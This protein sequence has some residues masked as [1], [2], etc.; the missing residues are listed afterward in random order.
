SNHAT[1][2]RHRPTRFTYTTLFR[3]IGGH[4]TLA[5][6]YSPVMARYRVM[7]KAYK[8]LSTKSEACGV[9]VMLKSGGK[10]FREPPPKVRSSASTRSEETRLNSSHVSISYAVFC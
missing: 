2:T 3:S 4:C 6:G 9:S 8:S 10:Y 1:I 7:P 5:H